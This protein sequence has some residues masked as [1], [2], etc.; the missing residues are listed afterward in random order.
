MKCSQITLLKNMLLNYKSFLLNAPQNEKLNFMQRFNSSRV[1]H[2]SVH[3][4]RTHILLLAI[5]DGRQKRID[6][7]RWKMTDYLH[8]LLF[9]S[10]H[11]IYNFTLHAGIMFRCFMSCHVMVNS[12]ITQDDYDSL[13]FY[14]EQN[15]HRIGFAV[16]PFSE[17]TKLAN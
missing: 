10:P 16:N 9:K 17:H 2:F 1:S 12:R 3:L 15:D 5:C 6:I 8:L 7:T 11:N 13:P 4:L 14:Y